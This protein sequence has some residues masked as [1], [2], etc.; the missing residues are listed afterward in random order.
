M[1]CGKHLEK[2]KEDKKLK[3]VREAD[4]ARSIEQEVGFTYGN[5][6]ST[7]GFVGF[8]TWYGDDTEWESFTKKLEEMIKQDWKT[9]A[10]DGSDPNDMLSRFEIRWIEDKAKFDGK[11]VAEIKA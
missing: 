2:L 8:R 10:E 11:T 9:E 6:K 7:T 3:V 1:N 4:F 5:Q